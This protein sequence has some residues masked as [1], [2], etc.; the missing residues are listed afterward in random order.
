[1]TCGSCSC[2]EHI[3]NSVIGVSRPPVLDWGTTFHPDYGGRDL[4]STFL[5]NLWKLIY[6]ATEALSDSFECIGDIEI[7][8]SISLSTDNRQKMTAKHRSVNSVLGKVVTGRVGMGHGPDAV[9]QHGDLNTANEQLLF[10]SIYCRICYTII[11][12]AELQE[13]PVVYM[14]SSARRVLMFLHHRF[15]LLFRIFYRAVCFFLTMADPKRP[16]NGARGAKGAWELCHQRGCREQILRS[17]SLGKD[18][19]SWSIN[20]FCVMIKAFS[21]TPKCKI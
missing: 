3:T 19:R 10:S 18:P 17:G 12:C 4:P 21:W 15:N 5:D 1:M 2:N 20:S 14:S 9:G 7:S 13:N 8:L 6:L 16:D 11:D